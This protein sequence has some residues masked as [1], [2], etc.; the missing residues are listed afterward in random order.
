MNPATQMILSINAFKPNIHLF[1]E[2]LLI[3]GMEA[4]MSEFFNDTT[5]AF[6]IMLI[7]FIADQ[8]DAVCC[9]TPITKRH[10]LRYVD[11]IFFFILPVLICI[12]F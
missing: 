4:I 7:V 10:W 8:Y 6:Y 1:N 9:H 2:L 11:A 12:S 3:S 5:T